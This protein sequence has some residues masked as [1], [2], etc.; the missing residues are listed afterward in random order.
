MF[1]NL[2]QIDAVEAVTKAILFEDC[3]RI[4]DW[5]SN[6]NLGLAA[7]KAYRCMDAEYWAEL[8][9]LREQVKRSDGTPWQTVAAQE[10]LECIRLRTMLAELKKE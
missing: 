2:E 8:Y 4:D 9:S 6:T 10:R 1:G 3:G 7:I 5:K